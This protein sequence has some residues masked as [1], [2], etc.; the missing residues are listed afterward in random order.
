MECKMKAIVDEIKP[1]VLQMRRLLHQYPELSNQEQ[2][3][4]RFIQEKLQQYGIT[5]QAGFAKYGVLGIIKGGSA[6]K[7]VA[8]RADMDA[9]PI[10]ELTKLPLLHSIKISCM[11][12]VMML[13]WPCF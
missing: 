5:Y 1:E 8:L 12:V 9:L 7:T 6:G 11:L 3:T 10:Q 2:E 13:I 4:S